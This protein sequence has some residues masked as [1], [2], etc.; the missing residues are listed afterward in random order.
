M[1]VVHGSAPP[2]HL[3]ERL[4][5]ALTYREL[6]LNL[7]RKELRVRYKD[8]VLGF[9]WSML[10][11]ILYLA[12]F[13]VVFNVFLTGGIPYFPVFMLSG[14]LPWT[15]FATSLS[16]GAGS[17]VANGPLLKK[18]SFPREVLPLASV[19]GGLFH[20][21][22]QML[23]LFA[24]LL[25]FRYPFVS[26]FLVLVPVA[27]F[28]EILLVAAFAILLSALTVYLRDIQHFIELALLA[29]F[30]MTPIIYPVA[31]VAD[32]LNP[33]GWFGFYLINPITPIIMSF[34]RAFYNRISPRNESGV[35]RVLLDLPMSW[36]LQRL[37]YV[38]VFALVLLVVA[39]LVFARLEG[40]FAEEL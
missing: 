4:T 35:T 17:V 27:I 11:P 13:Y 37:A 9:T 38:A 15:L 32:K 40:N 34:Q 5:R 29:W 7:V 24:F 25:V 18:V 16:T 22:L 14:L 10:N 23:V 12:V 30:W 33:R 2:I 3:L 6:L 1:H 21:F 39:Q 36:Y 20:F 8:S 28:V 19:G 26:E 31:L